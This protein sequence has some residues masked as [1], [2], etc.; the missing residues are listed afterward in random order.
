[1]RREREGEE[2]RS[3]KLK[4]HTFNPSKGLGFVIEE[5]FF[6]SRY[7]IFVSSDNIRIKIYIYI[8][9]FMGYKK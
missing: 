4:I 7:I 1:M 5:L 9:F 3:H 2:E 8:Y 6:R